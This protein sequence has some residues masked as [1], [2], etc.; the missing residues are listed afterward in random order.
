MS[1]P[2]YGFKLRMEIYFPGELLKCAVN[3]CGWEALFLDCHRE[4]EI[5]LLDEVGEA[6]I[7]VTTQSLP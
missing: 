7:V 4:A 3:R 1:K 5:G 2:C 6:E